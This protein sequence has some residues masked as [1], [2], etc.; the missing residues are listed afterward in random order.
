MNPQVGRIAPNRHARLTTA[1][2]IVL[3]LGLLAFL[4]LSHRQHSAAQGRPQ[5]TL[6][7][8]SS[9]FAAGGAIPQ[10][11]TCDGAGISP[12]LGWAPGPHGTASF[13]LVMHD[14]DAPVDFTHWLIYNI[15][16]GVHSLAEGASS[17]GA[18]PLGSAEG[19]NGF[20]HLGYGGPCPP[21][22]RPHHYVFQLYALD[23]R[24]DLPPG[25][26]RNT[27]DAAIEGHVLAQGQLIGDYGR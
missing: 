17:R 1:V 19:I 25:A 20:R 22:G 23:R 10:R 27:L 12:A 8:M 16:P 9:S 11:F 7:L 3:L 13:A 21:P 4:G 14:P 15:P 5:S 24:L 2:A 6:K 26:A 18:M